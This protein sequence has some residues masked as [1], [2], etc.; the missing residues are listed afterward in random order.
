MDK[1]NNHVHTMH[2]Y[3]ETTFKYRSFASKSGLGGFDVVT[4]KL[5][6][7]ELQ[8]QTRWKAMKLFSR[9]KDISNTWRL[10][11]TRCIISIGFY[12]FLNTS[13]D[14]RVHIPFW[15]F[16]FQSPVTLTSFRNTYA[17]C[18]PEAQLESA[19]LISI[20]NVSKRLIWRETS[21]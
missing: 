17:K 11:F 5:I 1:Y 16:W 8:V 7:C 20:C 15:T 6:H 10:L 21:F 19:H 3:T 13:E 2:P 4:N 9:S 12:N 18:M 14:A